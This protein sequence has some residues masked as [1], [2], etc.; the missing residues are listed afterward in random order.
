MK[1]AEKNLSKPYFVVFYFSISKRQS[2][3]TLFHAPQ[4]LVWVK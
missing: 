2:I 4:I 3:D 1:S